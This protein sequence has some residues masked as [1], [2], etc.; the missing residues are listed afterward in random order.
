[1]NAASSDTGNGKT[2]SYSVAHDPKHRP[3][4]LDRPA[5][6]VR[7]EWSRWPQEAH[8]LDGEQSSYRRLTV[9]EI[10]LIQGFDQSWVNVPGVRDRDQIAA[11]G[12]AVPP[13]LAAAIGRSIR[14]HWTF[15]SKSSIE[16]CAGIGGL[17]FASS[18]AGLEPS[19]LV[20]LWEPACAILQYNKPWSP[21]RVICGDIR[22]FD[23]VQHKRT[24]MLLGGPPCQPWSQAGQGIGQA[25]PRDL[26]GYVPQILLDCEPEV[27]LVENVPGLYTNPTHRQYLENLTACLSRPSPALAYGLG[28]ALFTAADFGVP[29]VRRRLFI[30]GFKNRS[31]AFA[32]KV[33]KSVESLATHSEAS[34][35]IKG[36][37]TW[38]TL[39][40]AFKGLS[41][42]GGWMPLPEKEISFVIEPPPP[43]GLDHDDGKLALQWP[44]KGNI[45]RVVDGLWLLSSP[46][47]AVHYR[48]LLRC[49]REEAPGINNSA[50]TIVYGDLIDALDALRPATRGRLDLVYHEAHR[51]DVIGKE[52]K[53]PSYRNS[54][55]L[56]ILRE[57]SARARHMLKRNGFYA[58]Q[59]DDA[60][61]HYARLSLDEE[62][63]AGNYVCTL[64]WQKKYGPQNDLNVP[65]AAQEYIIIYSVSSAEEL[66]VMG[67]KFADDLVDDGDPRGPWDAGHKGAKS[68][69]EET[70]F[71]VN[72]P[73]YRWEIISGELP[74]G[75][76][77]LNP[78]SGIIW[79]AKASAE[80]SYEILVK[81]MDAAGSI[82]EKRLTI[83]V[84]ADAQESFPDEVTWLFC[85]ENGVSRDGA[86]QIVSPNEWTVRLGSEFSIALQA[87]GGLP[88]SFGENKKGKPGQG[89]YW[90]FSR[91]TLRNAVLRD[92]VE[93]G[94]TGKALPSTKKYHPRSGRIRRVITWWDYER[95]GKS[96]DA[97]RH[98]NELREKGLIPT[99]AL[100]AKPES[101]MIKLL[102]LLAPD[103]LSRVL[104]IGD[105]AASMASVCVKTGRTPIVLTSSAPSSLDI[106]N[107]CGLPR[108]KAV[109]AGADAGGISSEV[110]AEDRTVGCILE[111]EVGS[112]VFSQDRVDGFVDLNSSDYPPAEDRL[113][114]AVG[115]LAGFFAEPDSTGTG[116]N[117]DGARCAILSPNDPLT[118]VNL[119]AFEAQENSSS[120]TILYESTSLDDEQLAASKLRLLRYPEDL[121]G[122][123]L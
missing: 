94:S 63:G 107:N 90:E 95:Y 97:S 61:Y 101:L 54:V 80:G 6:T 84:S 99:A 23:Y 57:C 49:D 28:V 71:E 31:G 41:D 86:L 62:F 16:I 42:P 68:G 116:Q 59:V 93:F 72:A 77:R 96:E 29:Q 35:P 123:K 25:D 50:A 67:F 60:S 91:S 22:D 70:K 26:L 122:R 75:A 48:P 18:A 118:G 44:G 46:D 83:K 117:L 78:F 15:A 100:V 10:A 55:W 92:N 98:L 85:D 66:P 38:V 110:A 108:L 14:E 82:A 12:N 64:V 47:D 105:N 109:L 21:S 114:E 81:V 65:T 74:P 43:A 4:S 3:Q 79:G 27:F 51:A 112:Y 76:W 102:D 30:L 17:T 24:G 7:R 45:P 113:L 39:R 111:L 69:S 104:C 53:Q 2:W 120:L 20:E 32:E 13:A 88:Y 37:Q 89:R 9:A 19:A 73:P 115:S 36:R 58:L 106:W 1:M 52:C 56:S 11:L 121:V 33:L 8:L 103:R 87:K 5:T 40:E 34:R 119:A